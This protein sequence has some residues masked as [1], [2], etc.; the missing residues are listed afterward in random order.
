MKMAYAWIAAGVVVV[1][2]IF[3]VYGTRISN[4]HG[5]AFKVQLHLGETNGKVEALEKRM[6]HLEDTMA[7]EQ[8]RIAGLEGRL[9]SK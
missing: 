2:L 8:Q 5:E 1:V 7:L 6:K 9:Y 3:G 4:A